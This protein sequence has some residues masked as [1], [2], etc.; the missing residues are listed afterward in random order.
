MYRMMM[1]RTRR[2]N[3]IQVG[4]KGCSTHYKNLKICDSGST[5]PVYLTF[6]TIDI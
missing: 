5:V 4:V 1:N 6:N 2:L 3:P